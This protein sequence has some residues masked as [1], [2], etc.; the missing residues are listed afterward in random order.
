MKKQKTRI[1]LITPP[2]GLHK[3]KVKKPNFG[4][5]PLGLFYLESYIKKYAGSDIQI[6]IYD[7]YTI[8]ASLNDITCL[9]KGFKPHIL[10]VSAVTI[11]VYDAYKVCSIAKENDSSIITLMGG[12]HVSSDPRSINHKDVD[13]GIN[14]EGEETFLE[15]VEV[16]RTGASMHSIK[17]LIRKNGTS[18]IQNEK[19]KPIADL[20]SIP[21]PDP[22]RLVSNIYNPLP[23]WGAKGKFCAM[24]TSRGCPYH[25][26]YCSVSEIQG[27]KYRFYS[28]EW[29]FREVRRLYSEFGIRQFSFRDG[30]FTAVKSRVRDFCDYLL[31][32]GLRISWSCNA[33]ANEL[34]DNI[35]KKM[36][37]AGC[38]SIFLGIEHGNEELMWKYKKLKKINVSKIVL[39]A[40]NLGL[41]VQGYFM[42][43]MPDEKAENILETI[44]YAKELRLTT[45]AFTVA[46]PLPGTA[47]Y[48][49]CEKRNLLFHQRWDEYDARLGLVWRHPTISRGKMNI[50]LKKAYRDFYLRPKIICERISRLKN[51][52]QLKDYLIL[53]YQFLQ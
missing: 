25:C 6:E 34:D 14:G 36:K 3:D 40:R 9:I 42:M 52:H 49:E 53:A 11:L 44:E 50:L 38:N 15:L 23:I 24:V 30:T 48:R 45:A 39:C 51:I 17:G 47:F 22:K 4:I 37:L 21:F 1:L 32:E 20:N 13:F 43:G 31:D 26:S 35:L 2:E 12:V 41:D 10:G 27:Q 7:G 16:L 33:R 8:G 5:Q 46:T 29:I 28:A 18:V 19:R